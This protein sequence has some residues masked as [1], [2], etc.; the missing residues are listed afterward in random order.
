MSIYE[1]LAPVYDD[2]FPQNPM[3]T[4]FLLGL[5]P[6]PPVHGAAS[7][8]A[9]LDLGCATGSQIL[10]LALAGMEASGY[11]PCRPMLEL[12]RRK[13]QERRLTVAFEE[14]GM[15]DAGAGFAPASLDLVLCIGNTLPHLAG[16]DE[17][18]RF[19]EDMDRL[20]AP[21]G[22]LVL[23]LLNYDRVALRMAEGD[24]S[25]PVLKAAGLRLSRSYRPRGDG[26]LDFLTEL[27]PCGTAPRQAEGPGSLAP[28]G[29][30]RDRGVLLPLGPQTIWQALGQAGFVEAKAFSGWTG[31]AFDAQVDDYLIMVARR[32]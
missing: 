21:G 30:A 17:L 5:Q 1:Q 31:K 9:V 20:L 7:G 22:R 29:P 11:E 24:Y 18:A 28:H 27:E 14:G 4:A 3:A 19:L 32:A 2:F 16:M 6:G 15:L 8:A 10:E 25:F 23:Q 12:A 26:R 13:A